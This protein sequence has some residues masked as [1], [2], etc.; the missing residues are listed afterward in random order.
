MVD[1]DRL[2]KLENTLKV[3]GMIIFALVICATVSMLLGAAQL[4]PF[5][6]GIQIVDDN[7]VAK[8]ELKSDG[9]AVFKGTVNAPKVIAGSV[10]LGEEKE[11]GNV[12]K[13]IADVKNRGKIVW[14]SR[15]V[16]AHDPNPN[17][18]FVTTNFEFPAKVR[19]A[20]V[21]ISRTDLQYNNNDDNELHR[22]YA[23]AFVAE[24]KDKIVTVK[25]YAF[26]H[27]SAGNNTVDN[28][29]SNV[30]LVVL[31]EIDP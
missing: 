13:L 16:Q 27:D 21:F 28:G 20:T 29:K 1:S 4:T 31:A 25:S 18:R 10:F 8:S 24:S 23:D 26:M 14:Q 3:Q 9:S 12:G 30:R 2:A 17:D 7:S 15:Q 5:R 22:W 11:D 19:A 6:G